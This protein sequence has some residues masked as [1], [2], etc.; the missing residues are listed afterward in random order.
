MPL[1][2]KHRLLSYTAVMRA[3]ARHGITLVDGVILLVMVLLLS[4]AL[5]PRWTRHL[6]EMSDRVA[7]AQHL[8][9]LGYALQGYVQ[10]HNQLPRTRWDSA[11]PSPTQYTA[12][13]AANPFGAQGPD[14]NDV[15][16][17]LFLLLRT[18][19]LSPSTF[20]CPADA[21]TRAWDFDGWTAGMRS[22][23][24]SG[25]FLGYSLQNPY[26]DRALADGGYQWSGLPTAECV[27]AA[28]MNPGTPDILTVTPFSE[29][30]A[31]QRANSPNHRWTGQ[32]V[33]KADLHVE[34]SPTPLCGKQSD[35]IYGINH[36]NPNGGTNPVAT[37]IQGP[38]GHLTDTVLL[39]TYSGKPMPPF[40]G[41]SIF[42]RIWV[43]TYAAMIGLLVVIAVLIRAYSPQVPRQSVR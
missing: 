36:L 2:N 5:L 10:N 31:L 42:A 21:H 15:T 24:P 37:A 25:E 30:A 41:R 23:F 8:S 28:D 13:Q 26:P 35:N 39:P 16:A 14:A 40:P 7:C 1:S 19:Q 6:S 17:A 38:P 27:M 20:V 12:P 32:N 22:N 33:L 43:S 4:G 3:R 29:P 18:Q 9:V 34:W 11:Q